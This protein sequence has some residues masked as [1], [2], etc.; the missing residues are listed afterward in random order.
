MSI[1]IKRDDIFK[2]IIKSVPFIFLIYNCCTMRMFIRIHVCQIKSNDCYPS[3]KGSSPGDANWSIKNGEVCYENLKKKEISSITEISN[4]NKEGSLLC[5][6]IHEEW[7][8]IKRIQI[9][10]Q[11]HTSNGKIIIKNWKKR[12]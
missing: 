4:R 11:V 6:F 10:T 9:P 3:D 12:D 8:G 2:K 5:G 7:E 1:K